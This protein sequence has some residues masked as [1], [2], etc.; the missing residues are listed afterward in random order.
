[1]VEADAGRGRL[2]T[3]LFEDDLSYR[4]VCQNT[5][6]RAIRIGQVVRR[7]G[8]GACGSPRIDSYYVRPYAHI[9]PGQMRFVRLKSQLVEGL[10]PVRVRL[11][12]LWQIG[13]VERTANARSITTIVDLMLLL[14]FGIG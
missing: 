5:Q 4:S 8:I 12:V 1:M 3:A 11:G 13:D 6:V 9:R 7:R 2:L 14:L 10:M